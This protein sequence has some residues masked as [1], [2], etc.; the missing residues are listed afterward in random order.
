MTEDQALLLSLI[1]ESGLS[2]RRFAETV[3]VR[4][5]RTVRRW[6]AGAPIPRVAV[7]QLRTLARM[8]LETLE[9]LAAILDKYGVR[10]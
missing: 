6:M 10:D 9:R 1:T 7:R 4:D 8:P 5:E 3:M 2:L